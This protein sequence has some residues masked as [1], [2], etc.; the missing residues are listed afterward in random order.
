MEYCD[1]FHWKTVLRLSIIW[2]AIGKIQGLDDCDNVH[3]N[4]LVTVV[5]E[6]PLVKFKVKMWQIG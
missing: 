2:G 5:Q 6:V 3:I 1:S 4:W